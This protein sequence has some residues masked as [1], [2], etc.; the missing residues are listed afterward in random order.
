M[1]DE[2]Y[3]WTFGFNYLINFEI[4][5][6]EINK[7][8]ESKIPENMRCMY[9]KTRREALEAMAKRLKELLDNE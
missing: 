3:F 1:T 5:D 6:L 7:I 9:Y 4:S 2:R 8:Y